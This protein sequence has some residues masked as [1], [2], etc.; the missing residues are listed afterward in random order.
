MNKKRSIL[1]AVVLSLVL[2]VGGI[3]AYFTDSDERTNVF[4]IGTNVDI[5]LSENQ[6]WVAGTGSNA[7]KYVSENANNMAPGSYVDKSPTVTCEKG[8]SDVYVF[9]KVTSPIV[10]D[11]EVLTY[12]KE[13][14][15]IQVGSDDTTTESGKVIRVYAYASEV[16]GTNT[17][18]T[19]TGGQTTSPV[20]TGVTIN[21]YFG[22]DSTKGAL[23]QGNSYDLKVEA[24]GIQT[25]GMTAT[26]LSGTWANF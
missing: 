18:T 10:D 17:L 22:S 7:G 12:T 23:I 21:E 3:L 25:E 2:V 16:S 26:D 5:I 14:G 8:K 4:T 15:W 9:V 24:Y 6:T 19:L 20:F 1:A 11:E 13:N